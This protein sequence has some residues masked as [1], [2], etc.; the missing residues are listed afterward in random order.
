MYGSTADL[1]PLFEGVQ[2]HFTI[3]ADFAGTPALTLPCGF[4]ENGIPYAMQLLGPQLSEARLCRIGQAY[5]KA[6]DWHDRHPAV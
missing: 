5:E 2:M 1:Q 6:T 3:P 4:S